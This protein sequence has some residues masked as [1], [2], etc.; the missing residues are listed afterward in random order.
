MISLYD[1]HLE[2]A[3]KTILLE[4]FCMLPF[5]YVCSFLFQR[6]IFAMIALITYQFLIQYILPYLVMPMRLNSGSEV[7]GDTIYKLVKMIPLE[8]AGSSIVFNR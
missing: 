4:P 3:P 6:E 7:I 2:Y 8:S 5:I 1:D